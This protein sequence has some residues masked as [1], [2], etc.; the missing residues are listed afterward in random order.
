M[1]KASHGRD[2]SDPLTE[3]KPWTTGGKLLAKA[4]DAGREL[5]LIFGY[6]ERLEYWA[7]AREI[8]IETEGEDKPVT[9]YRFAELQRIPGRRRERKD[10]IVVSTKKPLPN[11]F[12]KSYALVQT[13][14]FLQSRASKSLE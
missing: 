9:R 11:D 2:I 14:S 10:L 7:V 8:V 6:Y 5:A 4:Q 1:K 12:I 3:H 13:P